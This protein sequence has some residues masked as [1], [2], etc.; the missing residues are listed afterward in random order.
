MRS[1]GSGEVEWQ[2]RWVFQVVHSTQYATRIEATMNQ[3]VELN[4]DAIAH[5]GEA[6][7]RHGGKTVFVPYAIP[8]ERVRAEIVEEKER[9][10]RARLVKVLAP[11]ADRVAPPCP[12]F[13]PGQC[14]GC[15]WQHIAYE[16]Q[17][18][19]KQAIVADQ[20][21]RLGRI[22]QPPVSDTVVLADPAYSEPAIAAADAQSPPPTPPYLAFGYRNHV[23]LSATPD[24][25]LGYRRGDSH[26]VIAIDRCLLL[27]DRLDELHA[28]LDAA[29]AGLA[30]V[31]LRAGINTGDALILLETADDEQPELE[32][33]LPAAIALR[34]ANGIQPLIGEPCIEEEVLG[35]RYHISA[36]SFF[37]VNTVGAAALVELVT[38]YADPRP[39][40]VL[41]DAYCGVGLFALALAD[42]V[43][44]VIGIESS[45][46]ACEDFAIN[47]GDRANLALHEGAIEAV[48]PALLAQGQ[49]ADLVVLDPPRAGAGPEVLGQLA[50]LT[51]RRIIYV[52]CDPATL[53]RDAVHLAAAGYRLVEAQPVDLF[54]QTYH[55]ET[56][57]VWEMA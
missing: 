24:G 55:V 3:I 13:G 57:G 48:L 50:A 33:N 36:E 43:A 16:R 49:R 12:H 1:G 41:L 53:A 9:W 46:S 6:I 35:R 34:T 10:A 54:P 19:L 37:Q 2:G 30:G 5:G 4:L 47:A 17:A 32:I 25:R 18:E 31:S 44:E 8:G 15:Q 52:S 21:R 23:Q 29:E 38:A 42:Q 20:L 11:S 14:G 56:V 40:D 45:P 22:A 7:G 26:E 28:A 27:A 39:T 51:P